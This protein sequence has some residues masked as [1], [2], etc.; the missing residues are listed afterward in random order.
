MSQLS[1]LIVDDNEADRYLLRRLLR[2][3]KLTANIFE[4][5]NGE[6]ALQFFSDREARERENPDSFPP[7]L[8]FLDINMPLLNGF[9][10]LEAFA[11]LRDRLD[12]Q[13]IVFMMFSSSEQPEDRDKALSYGFVKGFIPKMPPTPDALRETLTEVLGLS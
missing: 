13:S 7:V 6:E 9:E 11:P 2:K 1:V 12:Y 10:F 3:S 8:V 5:S 4:V